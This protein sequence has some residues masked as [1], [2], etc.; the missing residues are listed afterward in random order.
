MFHVKPTQP[1]QGAL[2]VFGDR[3]PLA[4]RYAELL[5]G[6]GIERGLLGPREADR[7]W[8]RHILNSAAVAGLIETGARVVDIGSGAGLPGVPVAI[9][10]P[11]LAVTLVE[12]MLRR[13]EFLT[14]VVDEVGVGAGVV[15]GRAEDRSIVDRL[16]GA[17][18]V[19]SRAVARLE[20]LTRWSLPLLRPGGRM[21]ALK[22]D[23]AADEVAESRDAMAALG[24]VDVEVVQCDYEGGERP[25]TVVVAVRGEARGGRRQNRHTRADKRRQS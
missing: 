16:G 12:P 6:P 17:D 20:T 19:L 22:G 23:R 2:A 9:A 5:A 11:D 10:R 14:M 4:V 24:A 15:R 13:T 7:I 18:A 25:A 8:E 3:V 1:P 21:L